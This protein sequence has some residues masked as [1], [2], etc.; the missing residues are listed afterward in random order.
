MIYRNRPWLYHQYCASGLSPPDI[1]SKCGC[2]KSTIHR[3]LERLGVPKRTNSQAKCNYRNSRWK[4]GKRRYYGQL[5]HRI[6]EQHWNEKVPHGYH[7]HHVD[8]DYTN[9][10]VS[11]LALVT[12]SNHSRIHHPRTSSGIC[13]RCGGTKGYCSKY[14]HK[15]RDKHWTIEDGKRVWFSFTKQR[16]E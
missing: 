8:R 13:P 7:V 3:W 12:A 11:N 5:A 14:C 9:N 16:E 6:W 4:G 15:C 2:G 1:A 10:G